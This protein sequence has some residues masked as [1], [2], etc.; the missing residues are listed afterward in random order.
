MPVRYSA[1]KTKTGASVGTVVPVPKR[2]AYVDPVGSS[3]PTVALANAEGAAWNLETIY[4]GW[5][6]CDGRTLNVSEYRALYDVIGNTYGGV[7]GTTFNLPDYRSKKLMG[8]GPI[9]SS[10]SLGL[11]PNTGPSSAIA[12]GLTVAGSEGGIFSITTIRQL[13]PGSE[14]TP[15]TPGSPPS[16]GGTSTDTFNIGTFR[17]DGFSSA[18]REILS[19]FTA[20]ISWTVGPVQPRAVG[21]TPPHQ[22]ELR[23]LVRGSQSAAEGSPYALAARIGFVNQRQGGI[24]VFDRQGQA[25]A[26]H[27]HFLGLGRVGAGASFGND[28][29]AGTSGLRDSTTTP[30][31]SNAYAG[32]GDVG[33]SVVRTINVATQAGVSLNPG[34]FIMSDSSR[35]DWDSRLNVR[36]EAAEEMSMM[37]PYFRVKYIIK[38]Y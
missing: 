15:T 25:Q 12:A 33:L 38:A 37:T 10:S 2:G 36:L 31:Y 8:T 28:D 11:T 14:V 17:T 4:P 24:I 23:Y 34:N 5:L 29:A 19:N 13:P 32:G 30:F 16:I 1:E 9:D 3:T 6:P 18:T 20:N 35:T 7:A 21:G 22:H 27:S 26:S